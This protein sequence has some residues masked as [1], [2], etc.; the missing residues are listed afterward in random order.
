MAGN[1]EMRTMGVTG[2]LLGGVF[3]YGGGGDS[4]NFL[5]GVGAGLSA[6]GCSAFL[7]PEIDRLGYYIYRESRK[8]YP[9]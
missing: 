6:M 1:K 5:N 9:R 4:L 3:I 7:L 8:N 2:L